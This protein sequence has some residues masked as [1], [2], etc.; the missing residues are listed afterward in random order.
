MFQP[1]T[2]DLSGNQSRTSVSTNHN[3]PFYQSEQD[4]CFINQS[5]S[6]FLSIRAGPV[7]HQP[8]TFDFSI[9]QSRTSVSTN[10]NRPFYQYLSINQ[11]RTSVLANHNRPFY[12]SEQNQCFINQSQLTFLS[13]R[14]GPVF[15]P[16]TID[17]S[18]NK[19]RSRVSST[20]SKKS[21]YFYKAK[22][23]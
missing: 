4:Q 7:F 13:I 18:I 19:S 9:N 5:H 12:Q 17:L 1:I 10:H 2:F 21:L 11:S 6:S 3:R 16:I 23:I 8:I 14:A 22:I 15:Q 20:N